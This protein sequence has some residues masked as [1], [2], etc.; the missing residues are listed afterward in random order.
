MGTIKQGILGGFSGKVGSVI[1]SSW[2]GQA[3]MRGIALRVANPQT[4]GQLA[5]RQKFAIVMK[6]LQSM[7]QFIRVGFKNY[8][9]GMTQLNAAFS[10]NIQNAILGTYPNFTIDYPNALVSRGNLPP[11]LNQAAASSVAGTV[12]FTWTDNSDE[13]GAAA[14]DSNLLVIYNPVKNQCVT[15]TALGTRA[16]ATQAVTVPH[17][18]S[19]DLVHCYIAFETEDGFEQSNSKYAGAITVA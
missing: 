10:Y 17:S 4:D 3:V 9:V 5:Q 6:F 1:G 18:F 8:A 7:I 2:K 13:L 11:A 19:G 14:A 16:D 12:L 15:F